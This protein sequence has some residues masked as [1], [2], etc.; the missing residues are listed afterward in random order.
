MSENKLKSL[1]LGR[2][3][4][5]EIIEQNNLY[6][7]KT[8]EI[9]KL[10][11]GNGKYFFLSRPRRFGKT[12]LVS[13]LE[14]IFLGDKEL[15]KGLYIYDKINFK[16]YPV[17][18]LTMNDL[19]YSGTIKDFENS[20]LNHLKNIYEKYNL[21]LETE[22]YVIAFKELILKLSKNSEQKK[23]VLLIDEYDKPIIEYLGSDIERS[24]DMRDILKNFYETIKANDEYIHF[25]FLTGV[26]KFSKTSIFSSLNN[27][28][29]ITMYEQYSKIIGIDEEQ[30]YSY[31]DEYIKILAKKRNITVDSLKETLRKWYNGYSWDGKNFLYNPYS[32]L[33][34]FSKNSLDNYW[35]ETGTPTFLINKIKEY[36]VDLRKF[37]KTVLSTYSFSSYEVE[38][39]NI[40]A[41]LFQ[42]GYL[43]I[44][45]VIENEEEYE[46]VLSYPNKEVR[47]SMLNYLLNDYSG[48]IVDDDIS[49][50][51][52]VR[53]LKS[54]DIEG[55]INI[56]KSIFGTIAVKMQPDK[57]VS[58]YER[59]LYY[60]TIFYLISRLIGSK[61]KAEVSTSKGFI[62]AVAETNTHVYIFEFKTTNPEVAVNQIRDKKYYES[63]LASNKEIVFVGVS[64]DSENKNIKDFLVSGV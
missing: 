47:D 9:Y 52:M 15:F 5:K 41:L 4:F 59:E 44:K 37:E 64:F 7:D 22:D 24:K 28:T 43:T 39:I 29:D 50:N 40:Y 48:Q 23:V 61:I 6:V 3:V 34:A 27:L 1:P 45:E 17:I 2:Q 62:D 18:K 53:R 13:T 25:A 35:F 38:N 10:I 54:N 21:K 20:L 36:N 63:Y 49:I 33:S 31:F 60:H 16:K 14:S 19:R 30:L 57:K 55:L 12:L 32:L 8:E 26:S 42:T 11:N 46:Y 51:E 58:L 56:L